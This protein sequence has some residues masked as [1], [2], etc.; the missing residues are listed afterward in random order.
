[1]NQSLISVLDKLPKQAGVYQY[2]DPNHRLLYIGKAKNLYNR[3]RSYFTLSPKLSPKATLSMRIHKMV[4]EIETIEYIIVDSEHD[5][6][7]LEN[8]LI[9]QLNPKYNVLL[10]D[11]KTYPYFVIDRNQAFPRIEIT[12]ELKH[13]KKHEYF[14]PFSVGARDI[15]DSLYELLPLV[16]K[17]SC[18]EGKKACLYHQIDQCLAP[19]EGKISPAEYN[20]ILKKA[21]SYI[22][23][24]NKLTKALEKK[25]LAYAEELRFE[26]A[27]VLRDRISTIERSKLSTPIDLAS[28]ENYDIFAISST[29]NRSLLVKLFMREGKLIS[30]NMTTFKTPEGVESATL[31]RRSIID[32][33]MSHEIIM[34]QEILIYEAIDEKEDLESLL[35]EQ[36]GKKVKITHP[37]KGDKLQLTTLAFNNAQEQL[38]KAF[39]RDN[40]SDLLVEVQKLFKLQE[41]PYRIEVFDNSHLQGVASVGAM[42]TYEDGKFDKKSYR[43]YH[44][45]AVNEYEQMRE[46]LQKRVAS[47]DKLSPPDLWLLDGGKALLNLAQSLLQDAG[48]Y[49][50]LLAIS[51]EKVDA[52]AHRAKGKANDIIC[53][54]YEAFKMPS[55]DKRLQLLQKLRDEA[56]RFAITF[57]KKS[58]QKLDKES[59][60]LSLQGI[61]PAKV[62]KLLNY[63]GTFQSIKE[64]SFEELR[65]IMNDKDA[66]LIKNFY[67]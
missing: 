50:D 8:S 67:N 16:Q 61:G 41:L 18:V 42:I 34:P 46:T 20:K 47:F 15:Y 59:Q 45:N 66:K 32:Y 56:H 43:H 13:D 4:T 38:K 53:N 40:E 26:E 39:Q 51:K 21:L 55:S 64:A 48:I 1:M 25:M 49:I 57:H 60:L 58:K 23:D 3:V 33:Y 27:K 11:D 6:L 12:R 44:L 9:K 2:F 24:K 10:R 28:S 22:K 54:A 62:Q 7:I 30:S 29:Q 36:A 31:Y 63:F 35:S 14:G 65:S 17:K 5:A 52:K 37:F 19:C